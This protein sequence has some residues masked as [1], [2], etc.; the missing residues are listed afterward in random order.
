MFFCT[1]CLQKNKL[2]FHFVENSDNLS[3][4]KELYQA[5]LDFLVVIDNNSNDK[6]VNL[7]TLIVFFN[8]NEVCDS[9]DEYAN[10]SWKVLN[11]LHKL[12]EVKW[13][14]EIPKDVDDSKWSYCLCG[15]PIFITIST[16]LHSARKSRYSKLLTFSIQKRTVFNEYP[17]KVRKTISERVNIYDEITFYPYLKPYPSEKGN[18]KIQYMIPD[19]NISKCPFEFKLNNYEG[20]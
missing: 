3:S 9:I 10:K 7:I 20:I 4:L 11:E 14:N 15:Q 1:N 17:E 5:I 12:D 8:P 16:P 13:P 2:H 18:E 19:H 6:D